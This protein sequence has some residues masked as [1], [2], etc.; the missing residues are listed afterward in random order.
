MS[1]EH[2]L[3]LVAAL[4]RSRADDEPNADVPTIA[5]L[6]LRVRRRQR[7]W[8]AVISVLS[9]LVGVVAATMWNGPPRPP[10]P[11][12]PSVLTA[13]DRAVAASLSDVVG[14]LSELGSYTPRDV[15]GQ[16]LVAMLD[17]F[18]AVPQDNPSFLDGLLADGVY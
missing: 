7:G 8:T 18:D 10:P 14:G 6:D 9:L 4:A 16:E 17:P 15:P 11:R 3:D 12:Q 13:Q 1:A 5:E 2:D